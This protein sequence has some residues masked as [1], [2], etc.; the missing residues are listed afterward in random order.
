MTTPI[1]SEKELKDLGFKENKRGGLDNGDFY[2]WFS[3]RK[4]GSE[5]DIT[6]EYE[7]SK[8]FISGYVDFNC[9]KLK[10]K[11]LTKKDIEFLIE[12]M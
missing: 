8:T 9:E 6:Y 2:T 4:N 11:E 1:L 12:I 5:I 10:G 7:K 3:F